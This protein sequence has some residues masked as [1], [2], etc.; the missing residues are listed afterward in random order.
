MKFLKKNLISIV[1]MLIILIIFMLSF[2]SVKKEYDSMY[3]SQKNLYYSCLENKNDN[4][5]E[6]IKEF[7]GNDVKTADT[8]TVFFTSLMEQKASIMNYLLVIFL[9][10]PSLIPF[11]KMCKNKIINNILNRKK[12]NEF[13]KEAFINCY[14]NIWIIFIPLL[15]LF[16]ASLIYSGHFNYDY[17]LNSESYYSFYV[18]INPLIYCILYFVSILLFTIFYINIGLIVARKNSNIAIVGIE[19]FLLFILIDIIFEIIFGL[20]ISKIIFN[21]FSSRFNLLNILNIGYAKNILEMILIPLIL[22]I[23]TFIILKIIYKSKEKFIIDC[24]KNN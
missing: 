24:N 12:Y 17:I 19:S 4:C 14:K 22:V 11:C 7:E 21:S 13:L 15:I 3:S 1:S 18:Y 20:L 5:L 2:F 8:I 6:Y 9:V 16:I 23:I 10:V